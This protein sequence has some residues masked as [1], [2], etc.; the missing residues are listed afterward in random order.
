MI[1]ICEY[2]KCASSSFTLTLQCIVKE[3]T[4][5]VLHVCNMWNLPCKNIDFEWF[6]FDTAA[7]ECFYKNYSDK[8]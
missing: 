6:K 4:S 2:R 5:K 1:L 7:K 3:L 8:L